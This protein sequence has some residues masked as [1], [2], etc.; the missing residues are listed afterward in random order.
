MPRKNILLLIETSGPGG[1]EK[2]LISLAEKLKQK[3][4]NVFVCLLEDG[5]LRH[6]L[7]IIN[8]EPVI[9]PQNGTLDLVWIRK[10]I[11]Y[12]KNKQINVLHAHEFTMNTYSAI[13][14]KITKVPCITTVH[15]KNYCWEKWYRRLLYR[16]VSRTTK[17]VAVSSDINHF[18]VKNVGIKPRNILT[19]PNG[20]NIK[21]YSKTKE[22]SSS[23]P[24]GLLTAKPIIGCI[25]NLYPV[26]G[27]IY[28]VRAAALI[29]SKYPNAAFV[30]A[31]RGDMLENLKTEV[32]KL[33]LVN[34][35]H[36]L[37]FREDV[38]ALLQ[39]FDIFVLP[40]LSE[41][42]PLSVLESM[43]SKTP[44]IATNVGGLPEIIIDK[45]I[46]SLVNPKDHVALAKEMDSLL[47]DKKL[48]DFYT[49]NAYKKVTNNYSINTMFAKY[50][51]LYE[52]C[53]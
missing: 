50:L 40:S 16:F 39:L 22:P 12:I 20:I 9:I 3:N 25:G 33:H 29:I 1:A 45:N 49:N 32:K 38:P 2:I 19:I 51:S 14:S 4:Y 18:L 42:L 11:H 46:G 24:K 31:G 47:S 13:V 6:Q 37:G 41:G 23:L 5:W 53:N 48:Q 52:E 15:G 21:R 34:N 44:I 17:M 10:C 30:I 26:K 27:H 28:L 7:E 36:F 8:I 43:A 35:F